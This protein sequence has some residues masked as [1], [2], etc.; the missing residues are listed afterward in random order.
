MEIEIT[1]V[2]A[3]I[4]INAT[5]FAQLIS[6]LIFMMIINRLMYHPLQDIM[7]ERE[8]HIERMNDE[9]AT[10]ES[11]LEEIFYKIDSRKR[12]VKD[13]AFAAQ[14]RLENEGARQAETLFAGAN[15]EIDK[16]NEE[17]KQEIQRQIE[18]VRQHLAEESEKM[19]R[20]IMEKA[21]NR[22][23]AYE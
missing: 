17:T 22:R 5:L 10:G 4:S 20:I 23:L 9:I 13:E 2:S 7:A 8:R 14:Q 15:E 19:S 12:Q 11:D 16:L 18:E 21:L 1:R 6:F 3:L